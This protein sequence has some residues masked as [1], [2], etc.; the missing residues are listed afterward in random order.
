[1]PTAIEST[2]NDNQRLAQESAGLESPRRA[3]VIP[4]WLLAQTAADVGELIC[5][6]SELERR[7]RLRALPQLRRACK[8][9]SQ[10]VR[11]IRDIGSM[12]QRVM[13]P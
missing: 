6:L 13:R 5:A 12:G 9:L 10:D 7:G 3:I 8:R 4:D 1:M 2:R 11:Y